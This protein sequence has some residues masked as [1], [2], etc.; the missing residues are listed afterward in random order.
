MLLATTAPVR[1][2]MCKVILTVFW[3]VLFI[4]LLSTKSRF[5]LFMSM[6][7]D[8]LSILLSFIITSSALCPS[9]DAASI[10]IA[11]W[12]PENVFAM[13]CVAFADAPLVA[14]FSDRQ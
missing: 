5:A 14:M 8:V 10:A 13:I 11:H 12:Q 1:F 9:A 4:V 2:I 7:H 3:S 6:P